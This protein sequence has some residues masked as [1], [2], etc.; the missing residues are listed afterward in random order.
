MTSQLTCSQVYS[1]RQRTFRT[2]MASLHVL[3]CLAHPATGGDA[4]CV[5]NWGNDEAQRLSRHVWARWQ[6]YSDASTVAY[7][8]AHHREH[9]AEGRVG[10]YLWC[11]HCKP[12]HAAYDATQRYGATRKARKG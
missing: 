11:K 5:G 7:D 4:C 1:K 2:S 12:F 8:A 10:A 6:R 9:E 3:T